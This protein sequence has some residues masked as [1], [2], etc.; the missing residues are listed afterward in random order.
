MKKKHP[1]ALAC[2]ACHAMEIEEEAQF[3][4]GVEDGFEQGFELSIGMSYDLGE[5]PPEVEAR[6]Q[7]AYDLGTYV[8]ACLAVRPGS[9]VKV[10]SKREMFGLATWS[11]KARLLP[12]LLAV[13]EQ[14]L[15]AFNWLS[16]KAR[17]KPDRDEFKRREN[18]ARVAIAEANGGRS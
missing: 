11:A 3:M 7:W 15:P 17:T 8:G 18:A 14:A 16:I 9:D 12:K 4:R 6:R 1:L 2:A 10:E 13:A 5:A